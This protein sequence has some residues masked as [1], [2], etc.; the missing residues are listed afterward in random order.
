VIGK[1]D[2]VFDQERISICVINNYTD[3]NS[4]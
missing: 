4:L 2:T 3:L 1:T